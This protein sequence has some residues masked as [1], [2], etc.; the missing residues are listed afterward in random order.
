[1][2]MSEYY[3]HENI[4]IYS[5]KN[6]NHP[7]KDFRKRKQKPDTNKGCCGSIKES[8]MILKK[9]IKFRVVNTP[10]RPKKYLNYI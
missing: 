7:L 5:Y 1:M 2:G 10:I 6:Y 9:N 8:E 4:H 3:S